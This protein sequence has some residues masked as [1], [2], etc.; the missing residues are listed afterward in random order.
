MCFIRCSVCAKDVVFASVVERSSQIAREARAATVGRSCFSCSGIAS[1]AWLC[2][3]VVV[4]HS[5]KR[6]SVGHVL[7]L[8]RLRS[9]LVRRCSPFLRTH[10]CLAPICIWILNIPSVTVQPAPVARVC[11][12]ILFLWLAQRHVCHLSMFHLTLLEKKSKMVLYM[13]R[14]LG[15][16]VLRYRYAWFRG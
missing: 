14:W 4:F 10:V 2:H 8:A 3:V 13:A 1:S 16:M 7:Y 12:R 11:G 5:Y 15:R 9:T 6:H